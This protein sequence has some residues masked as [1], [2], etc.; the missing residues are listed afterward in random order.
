MTL[1]VRRHHRQ[2]GPLACPHCPR[3]F[4]AE[5]T[6]KAHVALHGAPHAVSLM[7][8]DCN[9]LYE[10]PRLLDKHRA[11]LHGKGEPRYACRT[12][13]KRFRTAGGMAAHYR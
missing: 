5:E 4:V 7:C 3:R 6:H 10:T 11:A 12:C 2:G 8:T 9:C 13:S 1:H